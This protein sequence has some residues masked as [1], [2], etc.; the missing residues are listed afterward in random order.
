[1]DRA[2]SGFR[3]AGVSI[4]MTS[5]QQCFHWPAKRGREG[6]GEDGTG[7]MQK[8]SHCPALPQHSSPPR[9]S[10]QLFLLLMSKKSC[11]SA[12]IQFCRAS[13][14]SSRRVFVTLSSPY[15]LL[16]LR[17]KGHSGAC[18]NSPARTL[19]SCRRKQ[20]AAFTSAH[21]SGLEVLW[22]LLLGLHLPPANSS[23]GVGQQGWWG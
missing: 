6:R 8:L 18:S 16:M 10:A 13:L 12:S 21:H 20:G 9:G 15:W 19:V 11:H 4:F 14:L 23:V 5:S 17:V 22:G 3:G 2:W 7:P 1:M